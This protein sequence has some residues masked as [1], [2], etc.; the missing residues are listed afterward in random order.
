MLSAASLTA[1][2]SAPAPA[3]DMAR[4]RAPRGAQA[5]VTHVRG[6]DPFTS[7]QPKAAAAAPATSAAAPG[8]PGPP[9][10]GGNA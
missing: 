8:P 10:T 9:G 2:C 6:G 1:F 5:G 7:S 4:P 3:G